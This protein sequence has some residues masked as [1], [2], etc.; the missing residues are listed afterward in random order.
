MIEVGR[1]PPSFHSIKAIRKGIAELGVRF[2]SRYHLIMI[3]ALKRSK[4]AE[5]IQRY[6]VQIRAIVFFPSR[7][8]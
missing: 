4:M 3:L 8:D 1:L 7:V 2:S 6:L 5:I